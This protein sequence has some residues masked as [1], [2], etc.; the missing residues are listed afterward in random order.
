MN[1]FFQ[2]LGAVVFGVP[3]IAFSRSTLLRNPALLLTALF[4]Y[5]AEAQGPACAMAEH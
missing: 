3:P 1:G 4:F 2:C 5:L